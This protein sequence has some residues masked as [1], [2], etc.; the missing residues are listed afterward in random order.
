MIWKNNLLVGHSYEPSDHIW[1]KLCENW[2]EID[3]NFDGLELY[4]SILAHFIIS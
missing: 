1:I 4:L 3:G 2:T